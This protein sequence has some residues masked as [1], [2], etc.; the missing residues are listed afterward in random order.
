MSWF[1][2]TFSSTIGRKFAMALSAIFLVLFLLMHLTTNML[3]VISADAFNEASHFMGTN[4]VVQ[5]LL[6]PVLIFAVVFHFVM[7]FVL[8]AKNRASRPMKYAKKDTGNATWMSQNMIYSGLVILAFLAL[9]FIDFWIPEINYK[10]VA[11]LPE[12]TDR[13]YGEMVHKFQ[14]P[15]RVGAYVIS[16]VLLALHLL[17]GFQSSLQSMGINNKFTPAIKKF[18]QA[19]AIVIPIGFVLIAL[20]HFINH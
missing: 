8:E 17:H 7:G 11:Q 20:Y 13:Y 1:S 2:N 15:L 9:H 19:Y 3:S 6:Q 4:P 16:F 14:N 10:Y 5:F 18:T 12:V